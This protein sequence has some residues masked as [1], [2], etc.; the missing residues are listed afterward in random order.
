[1]SWLFSQALVGEYLGGICSDGEPSA[2]SNGSPT[3]L[4]YLPPDKMTEFS[5]LSRFGMTFKP[6]TADRGAELLTS[7][8]A[9]FHVKTFHQQEKAPESTDLNQG[10]GATWLELLARYDPATSLWKTPQCSLFEDSEPSLETWPR[11]GLMHD[12][13]SYQQQTLTLRTK[14]IES[15]FWPMPT[16]QGLNGG[17]GSRKLLSRKIW[18]T[19]R[20]NDAK[21]GGDFDDMNPRNGLPAAVKRWPTPV[22]SDYS[23]RRP[24]E[25]WEGSNLPSQV[26]VAN[27]GIENPDKP[28]AKLNPTWVE[29]LMGWPLGWT[30]LKPL[31]T[32]KFLLWQ[33]SHGKF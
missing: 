15:G 1:M 2:P 10:C 4:A 5:R 16:T 20:S 13:V 24:T 11:W 23:A 30:D 18:P 7:Y 27:G 3:Q 33:N 22:K 28:P 6:L 17:S 21:K 32:D 29:W 19:P 8:L 31:E 26:W 14:E 12:G 9:D 25:T